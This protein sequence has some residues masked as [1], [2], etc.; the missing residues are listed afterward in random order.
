MPG[1]NTDVWI[2]LSINEIIQY[3]PTQVRVCPPY[4]DNA[5]N[6][7]KNEWINLNEKTFVAKRDNNLKHLIWIL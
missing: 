7:A 6:D 5:D 3:Y 4:A 1:D 2:I